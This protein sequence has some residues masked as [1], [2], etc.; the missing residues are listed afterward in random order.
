MRKF[1]HVFA[2]SILAIFMAPCGSSS[3]NNSTTYDVSGT[4]ASIVMPSLGKEAGSDTNTITDVLAV[5]PGSSNLSCKTATIGSDN[6]FKVEVSPKQFWGFFF[7]NRYRTGS[8]MLAGWFRTSW[9]NGLVPNKTTGTANLGTVTVDSD[10]K[11]ASTD[12]TET[13][14]LTDLDLASSTAST[15]GSVDEVTG[16]YANPDLDGD[17]LVDCN[18]TNHTFMLDFHMRFNILNNS[19]QITVADIIDNFYNESTTTFSYA[20]TGV[21]VA[22]PTAFSSTDTGSVKFVN[23]DVTTSEGGVIPKNTATSLVT[24]NNFSGYYGFGPNLTSTSNLPSGEIVFAFGD[25]TLTFTNVETPTLETLTAA[26]G[27]IFPFLKLN[28]TDSGCISN[29]TLS[30]IGYK[31]MKKTATGWTD[32]TPAEVELLV[33]D[34]GGVF[35]FRVDNN[36]SKTAQFALPNS[37]TSGTI[38][39]EAN[40][41]ILSGITA[42]EFVNIVTTQICHVGLSYDDKLGMRY[43]QNIDNA[44]G[45]CSS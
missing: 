32:A 43:F 29:C 36:S 22:Y 4:L 11:T 44:A 25:K 35:S 3:S 16:R 17:G 24:T 14:L 40:N 15:I 1:V 12:R 5:S 13:E 31:W 26:T 33:K 39:W 27:R 19:Q 38:L 21:Y 37:N 9:M 7:Y 28:K 2:V 10:N 6:T 30:S 41:A 23:T 42:A 8:N 20:S 45:T 18:E 34:T